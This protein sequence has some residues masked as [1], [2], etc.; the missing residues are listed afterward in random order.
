MAKHKL[1]HLVNLHAG[2]EKT[3]EQKRADSDAIEEVHELCSSPSI[4]Y[5]LFIV[6]PTDPH[7]LD[8]LFDFNPD[9][10]A[11]H[12]G[13]TTFQHYLQGMMELEQRSTIAMIPSGT[14]DDGSA[15]LGFRSDSKDQAIRQAE[16]RRAGIDAFAIYIKAI[17]EGKA[18]TNVKPIDIMKATA[19][20]EG[21][22][23]RTLY[24]LSSISLGISAASGKIHDT[25]GISYNGAF[26]KSFMG[27]K[28]VFANIMIDGVNYD[29]YLFD[30]S[31][32][33]G[34][35]FGNGLPIN[36]GAVGD[37]GVGNVALISPHTDKKGLIHK[38]SGFVRL[39]K[40]FKE[41]AKGKDVRRDWL[42]RA[43]YENHLIVTLSKYHGIELQ[44]DG[45]HHGKAHKV[46]L[47]VL[48]KNMQFVY[49]N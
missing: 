7:T 20:F 31:A 25:E 17:S 24:A 26:W 45:R 11:V 36:P 23:V 15:I 12:G 27:A 22:D 49:S 10:N 21:H 28:A 41:L 44:T 9:S 5:H 1:A 39:G 42:T 37:D 35:I 46:D 13:D 29:R 40:A 34:E 47:E 32:T 30:M 8:A 4:D 18:P 19:Y 16:T 14:G 33:N 6:D 2:G 43:T 48:P 3:V 38:L